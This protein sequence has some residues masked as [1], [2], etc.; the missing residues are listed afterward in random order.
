[1]RLTD[2]QVH[3]IRSAAHEA[4]GPGV[5]LRLF[6]SRVD[7]SRRGGDADLY[8][9]TRETNLERLL[10]AEIAFLAKLKTE[11]SDQRIDLVVDYPSR[12]TRPPILDIAKT[13]GVPL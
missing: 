3:T 1:M 10:D 5:E 6:G 9:A 2:Q 4:F 13:T 7:D 8:V 11:L 12:R